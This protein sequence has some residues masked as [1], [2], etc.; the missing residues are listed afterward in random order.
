MN[1]FYIYI[2]IYKIKKQSKSN[3]ELYLPFTGL[4]PS[5][6]SWTKLNPGSRTSIQVSYIVSMNPFALTRYWIRRVAVRTGTST[7]KWDA[8][9]TSRG[10]TICTTVPPQEETNV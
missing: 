9:V 2:Y 5:S 7:L 3:R 6:H 10:L 1:I 4:F 8:C